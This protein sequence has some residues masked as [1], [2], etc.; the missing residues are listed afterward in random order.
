VV[1]DSALVRDV[2][3][4]YL[5]AWGIN[6]EQAGNGREG[7][8]KLIA[9]AEAG[10]PY[11]V[12]LVDWIMPEMDGM[13]M[14]K[15]VR[16][17]QRLENLRLVL[18]TSMHDNSEL[19]RMAVDAG[20]NEVIIKPPRQSQLYDAIAA[21]VNIRKASRQR[22]VP[23]ANPSQQPVR[24]NLRLLLAEDN[25]ANQKLARLFLEKLGCQVDVAGNGAEVVEMF[26]DCEDDVVYD[27]ILMDCQMPVKDGY[28]ATAIIRRF[29]QAGGNGGRHI[30]IIAMT[31]N[32]MEGDR[33]RCLAAG[34]DDYI[35]KPVSF[36]KL[37]DVLVKSV[38]K[39]S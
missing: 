39:D 11:D 2:L 38:K 10:T 7:L 33:E 24:L 34:M 37:R 30:P 5:S 19:K 36:V 35:S 16:S 3:C 25:L 17:D 31:A 26:I 9:A 15:A 20:F 1:D 28:E 14:A 21:T 18:L 13:A 4:R 23:A 22:P 8:N 27:A 12:A 6:G 29:C 32:A